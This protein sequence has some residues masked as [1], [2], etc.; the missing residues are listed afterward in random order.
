MQ[1][2]SCLDKA[3]KFAGDVAAAHASW[4][5]YDMHNTKGRE[6]T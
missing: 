5:G 4:A 1:E 2:I 3:E 6:I